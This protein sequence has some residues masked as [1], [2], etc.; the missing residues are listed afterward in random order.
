MVLRGPW[1][2]KRHSFYLTLSQDTCSWNLTTVSKRSPGH[3]EKPHINVL[4]YSPSREPK[5]ISRHVN[6]LPCRQIHP[7]AFESSSQGLRHYRVGLTISV[8]PSI[9]SWPTET[10]EDNKWLLY[11]KAPNFEIICFIA[12][13]NQ[14]SHFGKIICFFLSQSPHSLQCLLLRVFR[15]NKPHNRFKGPSE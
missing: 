13:D 9:N 12:I 5:F 6:E 10:V 14:S 15:W 1:G 3:M 7:L 4:T 8:I 11:F 2:Y